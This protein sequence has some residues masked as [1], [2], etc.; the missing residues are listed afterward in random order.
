[1]KKNVLSFCGLDAFPRPDLRG[2][3]FLGEIHLNPTFIKQK[4]DSLEHMLVHGFLHL[5]GYDHIKK[6]D[7]ILMERMEE[8]LLKELSDLNL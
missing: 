5:L 7:R 1:M 2:K 6:G 4:G 8:G 3:L